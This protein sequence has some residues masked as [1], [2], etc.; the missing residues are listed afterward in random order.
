[1]PNRTREYLAALQRLRQATEQRLQGYA[2]GRR[3]V[4]HNGIDVTAEA[5]V[6]M[7]AELDQINWLIGQLSAEVPPSIAPD[8]AEVVELGSK[9][10][11]SLG[12]A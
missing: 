12:V 11:M 3:H 6:A 7:K 2:S 8:G 1:M 9:T 5:F 4:L 10:E